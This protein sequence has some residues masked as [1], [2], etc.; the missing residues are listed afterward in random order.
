[1]S[2]RKKRLHA[3]LATFLKQ[4]GRKAQRGQEP[5]DRG[6]SRHI[7]ALVKKMSPEQFEELL[8]G[9]E[10]PEFPEPHVANASES[11][12]KGEKQKTKKG[13]GT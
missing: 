7:E 6:Y 3:E 10:E 9:P 8:N 12:N 1:M 2:K 4:Y 13:G 11:T 5:N